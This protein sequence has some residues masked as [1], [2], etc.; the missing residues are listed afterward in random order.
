MFQSSCW[1][2]RLAPMNEILLSTV[3]S[4]DVLGGGGWGESGRLPAGPEEP[5]LD[6]LS[7]VRVLEDLDAVAGGAHEDAAAA[8]LSGPEDG[9]DDGTLPR[10]PRPVRHGGRGEHVDVVVV[11]H[12]VLL[13]GELEVV[14][15][16]RDLVVASRGRD[17]H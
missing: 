1:A 11:Q 7:H 12:P 8:P 14:D 13:G 4:V 10:I 17:L 2:T 9:R 16:A 3:L 5:A 6:D 15:P